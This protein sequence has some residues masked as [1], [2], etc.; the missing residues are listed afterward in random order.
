MTQAH[1]PARRKTRYRRT[2][3]ELAALRLLAREAALRGEGLA[4]IRARLQIPE[5]TLTVWAREDG[6]RQADLKARAEAEAARRAEADAVD[7]IRQQAEEMWEMLGEASGRVRSPAQRQVDLARVRTLALAEAGFLD[8]AEEE[9]AAVRRLAR[10]L[11]FGRAG[12]G[13]MERFQRRVAY[14]ARQLALEGIGRT[15]QAWEKEAEATHAARE[16]AG[17][18]PPPPPPDNPM[19]KE[20]LDALREDLRQS[21]NTRDP[22]AEIVKHRQKRE[23]EAGAN[24]PQIPAKAG[25]HLPKPP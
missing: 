25:I 12:S 8:A 7:T 19:S 2:D 13:E 5:P 1:D 24:P 22:W 16:A 14:E 17:L 11:A 18:P 9:I 20:D 23:E 6:F 4:S 3:R 10:L 15:L 21:L